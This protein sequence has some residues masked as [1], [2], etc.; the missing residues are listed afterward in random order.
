MVRADG[1]VNEDDQGHVS[2]YATI[3]L[4]DIGIVLG[5]LANGR[6]VALPVILTSTIAAAASLPTT[7]DALYHKRFNT[8][9][10]PWGTQRRLDPAG[11]RA[12][13]GR[14]TDH[15]AGAHIPDLQAEMEVRSLN[16]VCAEEAASHWHA[17]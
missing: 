8:H 10:A 17:V 5:I 14:H 11:L 6:D 9:G 12:R 15:A 1:K 13:Y 16:G 4:V 2:R 7:V 3:T